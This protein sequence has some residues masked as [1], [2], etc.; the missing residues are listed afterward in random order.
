MDFIREIYTDNDPE[1]TI[2]AKH[3]NSLGKYNLADCKFYSSNTLSILLNDGYVG[4]TGIDSSMNRNLCEQNQRMI[5]FSISDAEVHF[6]DITLSGSSPNIIT[7]LNTVHDENS[8]I[9]TKSIFEISG[10]ACH[11]ELEKI[12]SVKFAVSGPRNLA[13][14]LFENKKRVRIYDMEA[15][16]AS[17]EEDEENE[18]MGG[19]S[20]GLSSSELNTNFFIVE[21]TYSNGINFSK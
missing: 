20:S 13:A 6:R 9:I 4:L 14:F 1:V 12:T 21:S 2:N 19:Q 3:L 5:Q 15:D 18:N 11:R 16:E 8:V 7:K 17:D 10:Q